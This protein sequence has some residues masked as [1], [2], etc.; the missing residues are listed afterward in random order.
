MKAEAKPSYLSFAF[1]INPLKRS[2][3][4]VVDA[5]TVTSVIF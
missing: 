2:T 4:T 3:V 5:I 1:G